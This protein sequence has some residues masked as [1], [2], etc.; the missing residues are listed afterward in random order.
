MEYIKLVGAAL[1][2]F[3]GAG[4][5]ACPVHKIR[6]RTK[7]MEELYFCLLRLR[8]EINH[9]VR[10]LPEAFRSAAESRQGTVGGVY[11]NAMKQLAVRMERGRESY[12]VLLRES[13]QES[14]KGSVLT[15]E[16]QE[17]FV[18]NFLLLGG[19]DRERQ[20]QVLEYYAETVRVAIAQE[21]QKKKERAYLYRSLG[22]LGGIFLS[23]ILY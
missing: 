3:A 12:E 6:E 2:I 5:G 9:A 22:V 8:S 7:E 11:R 21:K 20:S 15:R 14:F 19:A 10:P 17:V 4:F 16:E 18:C 1:V 13:A 23:V